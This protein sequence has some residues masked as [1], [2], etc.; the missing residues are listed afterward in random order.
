M[1]LHFDLTQDL[2]RE[3]EIKGSWA[4][5]IEFWDEMGTAEEY[6]NVGREDFA[7]R[8]EKPI[9]KAKQPENHTAEAR[10]KIKIS[11]SI[12]AK[13]GQPSECNGIW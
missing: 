12:P 1:K 11:A 7:E 13:T 9:K 5:L 8:E 2:E 6:Q 3:R 4:R 10:K